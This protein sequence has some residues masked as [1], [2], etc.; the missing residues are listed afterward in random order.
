M[1]IPIAVTHGL[2][3]VP[4]EPRWLV[5]V[6]VTMVVVHKGEEGRLTAFSRLHLVHEIAHIQC[7]MLRHVTTE[8]GT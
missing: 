4:V 2:P 3:I 6:P 1:T 7:V 5:G 8:N